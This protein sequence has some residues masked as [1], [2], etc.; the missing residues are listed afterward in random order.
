MNKIYSEKN[1]YVELLE[2]IRIKQPCVL[3]TVTETKGSTPQKPGSS[4]IFGPNQLLAGTVGGG[5]VELKVKNFAVKA[6]EKKESAFFVFNLNHDISND[7]EAICGGGMN[8]LLDASPEK[9]V[10]VFEEIKNSCLNRI[11]GV[12]ATSFVET[13]AMVKSIERIWITK[14]NSTS[15][16][17]ALPVETRQ[18]ID[19][20]LSD[21]IPDDFKQITTSVIGEE[22]TTTFFETIVP[23]PQL[24]VAGAGH[25]GKALS[26]LANLLDFDVIVWDD[27]AE[28][29]NK[30]NLP[31][32]NEILCGNLKE[33]LGKRKIDHTSYLVI[34]TSNHKNDV[35]VLRA[36][37]KLPVAY[38]GMIGS[39][40]KIEQ[41][42]KLFLKQK[43]ATQEEWDK[44]Y[45]P[46]GLKIHSK[47]VQEIALSIAAQLVLV[48]NQNNKKDE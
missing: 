42:R 6:I 32:A 26:H 8:I 18:R 27:R 5:V 46:I 1:I 34:V 10:G 33:S 11:P 12:M 30:E 37:I 25:V 43:W 7:S 44:I 45:T 28:Y 9:H 29:A 36:F 47:T 41:V 15:L 2:F 21:P 38:I 14:Q 22:R 35:E 16:N 40:K 23:S 19:K 4:A 39:K 31:D 20:M 3:S 17:T 13:N 48:R 24:I